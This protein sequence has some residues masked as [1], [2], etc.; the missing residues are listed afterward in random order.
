MTVPRTGHT[1]LQVH[2]FD[3]DLSSPTFQA[4]LTDRVQKLRF[5]TIMPGGYALCSFTLSTARAEAWDWFTT[6]PFY[7]LTVEDG[8]K[9]VFE[10]RL[11]HPK[12]DLTRGTT[13]LTF[14][15]YYANLRDVAWQTTKNQLWSTTI[16]DILTD[17]CVQVSSDQ[18][19]IATTDITVNMA[20]DEH[21]I[22]NYPIH[23]FNHLMAF[24]DTSDNTY[25]FF[26][27][28]DRIPFLTVR[29]V[30]T[31]DWLVDIADFK[32]FELSR[33]L[34]DVWNSGYAVYG[35][36][37]SQTATVTD[38]DSIE[39][40]GLTRHHVLPTVGKASQAAAEAARDVWL[41]EYKDVYSEADRVI[42]GSTVTDSGGVPHPSSWVR[43]GDVIRVRDLVP[44]SG[45][46]DEVTRDQERT[47]FIL[48]THYDAD[49]RTNTLTF[50]R[51]PRGLDS[52][53]TRHIQV[54]RMM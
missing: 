39:R 19:N 26:I 49:A 17:N 11:E 33:D 9:T 20:A 21:T 18:S 53:L 25:D 32:A 14:A 28:E 31:V 10:G 52:F 22:N 7:R 24:G 35:A 15:G 50:D 2:L 54:A 36:A 37:Q 48:E 43:S 40:F 1:D 46:L 38:T 16:K 4:N 47:Y 3:S 51:L 8:V 41:A 27:Y 6:R 29:S 45:A 23:I 34:A 44:P 30:S 13:I 5:G 12:I 42:L